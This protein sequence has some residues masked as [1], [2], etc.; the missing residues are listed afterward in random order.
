MTV[1]AACVR[2]AR[3]VVHPMLAELTKQ[4]TSFSSKSQGTLPSSRVLYIQMYNH[5]CPVRAGDSTRSTKAVQLTARGKDCTMR[6]D[7]KAFVRRQG[8][9]S[10]FRT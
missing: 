2:L 1:A 9:W 8:I 5:Q 3:A 4:M 10:T 7:I 6:A